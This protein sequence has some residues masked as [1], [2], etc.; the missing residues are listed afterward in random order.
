MRKHLPKKRKS[1]RTIRKAPFGVQSVSYEHLARCISDGKAQNSGHDVTYRS[2]FA[3]TSFI[4]DDDFDR[5]I[6]VAKILDRHAIAAARTQISILFNCDETEVCFIEPM[7]WRMKHEKTRLQGNLDPYVYLHFDQR[8]PILGWLSNC[9]HRVWFD[10]SRKAWSVN[11]GSAMNASVLGEAFSECFK[12]V[13]DME[14]MTV[15]VNQNTP[16]QGALSRCAFTPAPFHIP[17]SADKI[18]SL[19]D[20]QKSPDSYE[21]QEI[22]VLTHDGYHRTPPRSIVWTRAPF[23]IF[24][25]GDERNCRAT[26]MVV[27]TLGMSIEHVSIRN[28][29]LKAGESSF[30]RTCFALRT[31][32]VAA[33]SSEGDRAPLGLGLKSAS[34]I[35]RFCGDFDRFK[36]SIQVANE[37]IDGLRPAYLCSDYM[38]LTDSTYSASADQDGVMAYVAIEELGNSGFKSVF[39]IAEFFGYESDTHPVIFVRKSLEEWSKLASEV[40][41]SADFL[42]V[43]SHEMGHWLTLEVDGEFPPESEHGIAWSICSDI[44]WYLY[45]GNFE[46]S[47][48][49]EYCPDDLNLCQI[50]EVMI[51]SHAIPAIDRIKKDRKPSKSDIKRI[52]MGCLDRLCGVYVT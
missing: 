8:A 37:A 26:F 14:T 36:A 24:R 2:P 6:M 4:T 51:L 18:L 38:T 29:A 47:R 27:S 45:T 34:K 22:Y 49:V 43:L 9:L 20:E 15:Y 52:A 17:V 1:L 41:Y 10:G 13:F 19:F 12:I 32:P 35:A 33:I 31:E 44:V 7:S 50:V 39:S 48:L 30:L 25:R 16:R 23:L 46:R 21:G 3:F 11:I 40:G 5:I 42:Y 28:G